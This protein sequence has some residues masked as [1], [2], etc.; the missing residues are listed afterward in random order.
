[1]YWKLQYIVLVGFRNSTRKKIGTWNNLLICR[2]EKGKRLLLDILSFLKRSQQQHNT[3]LFLT[4]SAQL[5]HLIWVSCSDLFPHEQ[6]Q[7]NVEIEDGIC[8][9]NLL[10]FSIGQISKPLWMCQASEII[11]SFKCKWKSF[12]VY[13]TWCYQ[14]YVQDKKLNKLERYVNPM[15]NKEEEKGRKVDFLAHYWSWR[16]PCK[17]WQS[18]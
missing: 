16:V 7:Q 13:P 3:L 14:R 8:S 10:P 15:R 11:I 18:T 5:P 2:I 12:H 9:A 4:R 6:L 1:M 17:K